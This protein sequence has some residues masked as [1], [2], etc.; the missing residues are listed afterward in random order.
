MLGDV[1]HGVAVVPYCAMCASSSEVL[2]LVLVVAVLG[3][4][5]EITVDVEDPW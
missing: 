5:T 3:A 2:A 4:G 1:E